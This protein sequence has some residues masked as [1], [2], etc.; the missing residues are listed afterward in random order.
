MS[1]STLFPVLCLI[2]AV[3]AACGPATFLIERDGTSAFFGRERPYLHTMLCDHAELKVVLRD[4]DL[5]ADVQN[6]FY[7]YACSEQRSYDK[8]A[9]LYLFL[10]PREKINLKKAF[11]KHGYRVNYV[12]C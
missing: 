6:D 5:P 11:E 2:P 3:V 7:R 1:R 4:A 8:V 9:S 12:P 10:T